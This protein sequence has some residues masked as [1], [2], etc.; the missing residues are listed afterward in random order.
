MGLRRKKSYATGWWAI[1]ILFLW[2]FSPSWS[3]AAEAH[4]PEPDEV[5]DPAAQAPAS[6]PAETPKKV[7][8]LPEDLEGADG[9][10]EELLVFEDIPVVISASRQE[11]EVKW[12]SVPTSIVTADD[13][14]YSGLTDIPEILRYVPGVDVLR[15]ERHRYAVGVHGLEDVYSD[16]TLSLIDGRSAYSPFFG[17]A[18]WFRLPLFMEDI[19]RIEVVQGPGGAAWGPN[20]FNGVI[21]MITKEP[22]DTQGWFGSTTWNH[23]GDSYNHFRWGA[24]AGDLAWRTSVGYLDQKGSG[25]IVG[26]HFESNHPALNPLSGFAS[27]EPRDYSRNWITD[28]KFS[29][30]PSDRTHISFGAAYSNV[31][32][33]NWELLGYFPTDNQRYETTRLFTKIEQKG[34]NDT[35]GYLQ[36]FGNIENTG[37]GGQ[38]RYNDSENDIEAQYNFTLAEKHKVSVGGNVRLVNAS[39]KQPTD[40]SFVFNGNHAFKEQFVGLFAIDRWQ[41]TDRLVI[42]GQ[43]RGD[44]YSETDTDWAGRVTAMYALDQKKNHVLRASAA[45]AFRT[46]SILLRGM[47][48][49]RVRI[50]LPPFLPDRYIV[51]VFP[52]SLRNE[53]MYSLEFGYTGTL[54]KGLTVRMNGFY[55]DYKD[56]VGVEPIMETPPILGRS[57]FDYANLGKTGAWGADSE[58]AYENKTGKLSVWYS[59]N[60]GFDTWQSF[61]SYFPARHKTGLTGRLFLPQDWTLNTNFCFNGKSTYQGTSYEVSTSEIFRLDLTVSKKFFRDQAEFMLG[62]SDLLADDNDPVYSHGAFAAHTTP[63]RTF[64]VRFQYNF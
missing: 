30:R 57:F 47:E 50:P 20:A 19:E 27:Y 39:S 10:A 56:L 64:F 28:N 44:W 26:T 41:V 18:E 16:R 13:I 59:Y 37:L 29:Y 9:D 63:G 21:N 43:I 17:G 1:A 3:L 36:W 11:T 60:D 31:T 6:Q 46:P 55:Q 14:H 23:F 24:K 12:L 4:T 61:R 40:E 34:D 52:N 35:S 5:E 32:A 22:E 42:E 38:G 2:H 8:D 51:N 58:L 45:K 33:G 53:E 48:T 49:T 62:V 25:D 54:A 7:A 15:M